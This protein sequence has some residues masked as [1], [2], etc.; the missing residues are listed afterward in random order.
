MGLFKVSEVDLKKRVLQSHGHA[1]RFIINIY[2]K[3]HYDIIYDIDNDIEF[4]G[5]QNSDFTLILW[6][7]LFMFLC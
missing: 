6:V 3:N 1:M 7:L 5:N 2:N 4:T